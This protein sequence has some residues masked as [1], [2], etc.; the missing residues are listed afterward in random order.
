MQFLL[1]AAGEVKKQQLLRLSFISRTSLPE[2]V[3]GSTPDVRIGKGPRMPWLGQTA[4]RRLRYHKPG[5]C[6][7]QSAEGTRPASVTMATSGAGERS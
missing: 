1:R 2:A 7:K 4:G 3:V 6:K 5:S